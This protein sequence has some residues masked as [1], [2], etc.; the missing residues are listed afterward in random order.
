MDKLE[1]VKS[2]AVGVRTD[3]IMLQRGEWEPDDDSCQCSIDAIQKVID[4]LDALP[5]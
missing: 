2:Y 4:F 3:L 5:A 1:I